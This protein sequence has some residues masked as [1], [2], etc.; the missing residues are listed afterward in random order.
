M[1]KKS[2]KNKWDSNGMVEPSNSLILS[3][4]ICNAPDYIN[5]SSLV[6]LTHSRAGMAE[7]LTR[8][9]DTQCPSGFVGSIPTPSATN[10]NFIGGLK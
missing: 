9:I 10:I 8:L 4:V 2:K 3:Y 5:V 7:W 6:V 1:P